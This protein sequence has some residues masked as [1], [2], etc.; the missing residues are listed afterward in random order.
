M[1]Q[2]KIIS[3]LF[4]SLLAVILIVFLNGC[5]ATRSML[6]T[7]EDRSQ[8]LSRG[9][10]DIIDAT[11]RA[12]GESRISDE[13]EI[14]QVRVDINPIYYYKDGFDIKSPVKI[15]VPLPAIE[16]KAK[17]F[18]QIG[19]ST[20][21]RKSLWGAGEELVDNRTLTS[22]FLFELSKNTKT[23][24]KVDS[25]WR[26]NGPQI[27]VR[28]FIRLEIK[29]DP[30][31]F[32]FEE[33]LLWRSD[34]KFGSRTSIQISHLISDNSFLRYAI[35]GEY[36]ELRHGADFR[37]ALLYRRAI[38]EK[39][40]LSTELGSDFNPHYGPVDKNTIFENVSPGELDND[41]L[42]SR[43]QIIGKF[44]RKWMEYVVEPGLDYYFHHQK[45]W[46]YGILF[47]LRIIVFEAFLR[48]PQ[49]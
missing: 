21:P 8:T 17:F 4:I 33:Q 39:L 28:P 18:F 24:V 40:A 45:P 36:G 46:D 38:S 35:S 9:L 30:L 25:Y 14:V 6:D 44:P 29:K 1:T 20:D 42:F 48:E 34:E 7:W 10:A 26:D 22:G 32:F 49:D 47:S 12:F 41:R 11:D 5:A 15:R 13:E 43:F 27:R 37:C 2:K 3:H 23:G 31:R 16:R 19:S